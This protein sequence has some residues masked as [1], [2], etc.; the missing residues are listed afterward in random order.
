MKGSLY[1][2]FPTTFT[3]DMGV[4]EEGTATPERLAELQQWKA[5]SQRYF[6]LREKRFV[7]ETMPFKQCLHNAWV[8]KPDLRHYADMIVRVLASVV[9]VLLLVGWPT[10]RCDAWSHELACVSPS[11]TIVRPDLLHGLVAFVLHC[12]LQPVFSGCSCT[13]YSQGGVLLLLSGVH[14]LREAPEVHF[15]RGTG[16][17]HCSKVPGTPLPPQ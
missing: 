13:C 11:S 2:F 15:E 3:V 12:A 10:L 1:D 6:L 9:Y 4:F 5:F 8:V 14:V 17:F 16:N 7:Q